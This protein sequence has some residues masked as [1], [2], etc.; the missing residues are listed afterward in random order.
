MFHFSEVEKKM[1]YIVK[2]DGEKCSVVKRTGGTKDPVNPVLD[3][4]GRVNSVSQKTQTELWN[5]H[6]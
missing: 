6:C 3:T 4:Y 1:E 2:K 5:L